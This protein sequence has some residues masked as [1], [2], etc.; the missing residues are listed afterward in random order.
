MSNLDAFKVPDSVYRLPEDAYVLQKR[1]QLN[2]DAEINEKMFNTG[3]PAV[4]DSYLMWERNPEISEKKLVKRS[5]SF[6]EVDQQEADERKKAWMAERNAW[7][8]ELVKAKAAKV[9]SGRKKVKVVRRRK[10]RKDRPRN[11]TT[12]HLTIGKKL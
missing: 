11:L 3:M 2:Q 12:P 7:M 5:R 10:V 6:A 1:Y 9:N 4:D 8:E